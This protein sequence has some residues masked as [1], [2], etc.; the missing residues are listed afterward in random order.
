MV[1]IMA[2]TP[3]ELITG[4]DGSRIAHK[5]GMITAHHHDAGIVY[6]ESGDPY[7]ITILTRGIQ[8]EE[9]STALGREISD[10]VYRHLRG[11]P[12]AE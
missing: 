9:V 10:V 12:V 5:T 6:P 8:D 7:V 4:G 1:D 3:L 11:T 2:D